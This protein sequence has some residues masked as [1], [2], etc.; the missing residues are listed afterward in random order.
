MPLRCM[1]LPYLTPA[2]NCLQ[3]NKGGLTAESEMVPLPNYLAMLDDN[4]CIKGIIPLLRESHRNSGLTYPAAS[5]LIGIS[6]SHYETN[7]TNKPSC[8]IKFLRRFCDNIDSEIFD[9]IYAKPDFS[10]TARTKKVLLPKVLDSQLAYFVGYLQGD[11]CLTSDKKQVY[12]SDEYIE[13]IEQMDLLSKKLF[14]ITGHVFWTMSEISKKPSPHLELKSVVLNSFLNKVFGIN[15]GEK[16]NLKMPG[17]IKNNKE[18]LRVYISGLFDADGTLPKNILTV[19]QMFIDITMKDKEFVEEIRDCLLLYGIETLKMYE[20]I[21]KSPHSGVPS[22]TFELRIRRK[23]MLFQF[24][25]EIGFQH[26]NK[27]IR[28]RNMC[29]MAGPLGLKPSLR[30]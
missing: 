21:A 9:K 25:S 20:R 13:Q 14:G 29:Q 10:F 4:V 24:L 1:V 28:A 7:L 22:S 15:R 3:S 12:F 18:L 6:K 26:P 17:I 16:A 19:K 11:G 5:K 23:E 8:S 2:L 27:F 30:V